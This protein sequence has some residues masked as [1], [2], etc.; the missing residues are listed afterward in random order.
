MQLI[1]PDINI[2]FIGKRKVAVILS[3]LLILVGLVSMIFRG[4]PEYGIDFAGGTLVQI[5]FQE[6]TSPKQIRDALKGLE[7][8]AIVVQQF[9]DEPNEYLIRAQ[10]SSSELKGLRHTISQELLVRA[11]KNATIERSKKDSLQAILSRV[12]YILA[13]EECNPFPPP[14]DHDTGNCGSVRHRVV[15]ARKTTSR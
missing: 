13:R 10:Q 6:K 3:A 11:Q 7:L 12:W 2:D 4:G 14:H 8:G 15:S 9:G 1:K 5:Q